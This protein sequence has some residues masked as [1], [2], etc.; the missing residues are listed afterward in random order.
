MCLP[1]NIVKFYELKTGYLFLVLKFLMYIEGFNMCP[2]PQ[3]CRIRDDNNTDNPW[4]IRLECDQGWPHQREKDLRAD[5]I[6]WS[7][8][9]FVQHAG[10]G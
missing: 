9:V 3:G 1:G 10:V 2:I 5:R 8:V 4:R 7:R 6:L